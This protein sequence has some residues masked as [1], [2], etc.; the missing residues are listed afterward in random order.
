MQIQFDECAEKC[1]CV[2]S[3]HVLSRTIREEKKAMNQ[4]RRSGIQKLCRDTLL[5][6]M[7]VCYVLYSIYSFLFSVLFF[8][9]NV[10]NEQQQHQQ[11]W[12]CLHSQLNEYAFSVLL[13]NENIF[14]S[15]CC[16]C[17]LIDKLTWI[18]RSIFTN[19]QKP[20]T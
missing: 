7:Y 18:M 9:E 5:P 17:C 12:L 10:K 20:Y 14:F 19:T 8:S 15:C 13:I 11:H 2:W 1:L 3:F 4:Q 6:H 16:C